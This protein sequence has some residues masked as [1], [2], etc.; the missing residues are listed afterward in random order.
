MCAT[1]GCLESGM[2]AP[3]KGVYECVECLDA[4]KSHKAEMKQND[5]MPNCGDCVPKGEKAHWKKV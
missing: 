1:C 4:G 5:T 2:R 3:E